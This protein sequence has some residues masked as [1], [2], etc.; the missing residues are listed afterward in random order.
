MSEEH[1]VYHP[2]KSSAPTP[3]ELLTS[4][5]ASIWLKDALRSA[6]GRD[7]VDAARDAEL[8][9]L[10]LAARADSLLAV[11]AARLG[12]SLPRR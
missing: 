12:L 7:P 10:V 11:G 3:D 6:L 8:L 5:T 9:A 1:P 2:D 4:L